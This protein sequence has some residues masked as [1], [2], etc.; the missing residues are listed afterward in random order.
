M[1]LYEDGNRWNLGIFTLGFYNRVATLIAEADAAHLR[2]A[3]D[4]WENRAEHV[5]KPRYSH[6]SCRYEDIIGK[7]MDSPRVI[8]VFD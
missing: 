2:P 4:L 8:I 3:V 7:D 5:G 1:P 6:I